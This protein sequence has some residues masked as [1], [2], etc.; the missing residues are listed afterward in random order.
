MKKIVIL[1]VLILAVYSGYAQNNINN[2]KYVIVPNSFEFLSSPNEY[3]LNELSKFLFEKYNFTTFMENDAFPDEVLANGCL[4][5][6][7]HVVDDS[8]M[9][10]T[11]LNIELKNCKGEIVYS[12]TQGTSREKELGV[13]YNKALRATFMSFESLNYSYKPDAN[14]IKLQ[15]ETAIAQEQIVSLKKEIETLKGEKNTPVKMSK[16]VNNTLTEEKAPV[17]L[18]KLTKAVEISEF[19]AQEIPN[20]YR[21]VDS[22][23]KVLFTLWRSNLKDVF[24]VKDKNAIV[25][26]ENG[27][28]IYSSVENGETVS[29]AMAIQF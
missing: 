18:V 21:V 23:K 1:T 12:T 17:P 26:K 28:Y 10:N 9:L 8:G 19:Y 4:A 20:G 22:T 25:Y 6:R 27:S 5:L 14:Q 15:T 11:K 29:K 24:I 3:R 7:A 2:Y 16:E 13:A